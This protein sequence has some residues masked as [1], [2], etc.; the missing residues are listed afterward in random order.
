MTSSNSIPVLPL[1]DIVVFPNMVVPLFVGRE[2]SI[3][4][5][6][7][8]MKTNKKILL[9]TQ[10]NPNI[11]LPKVEDLH[12]IGTIANVLQLLKLPDGTLKVLVEGQSKIKID[13][14]INLEN[15]LTAKYTQ[16]KNS[17]KSNEECKAYSKLILNLFESIININ[18]KIPSEI[19]TNLKSIKDNDSLTYNIIPHLNIDLDKKQ[20]LLEE[21]LTDK[22]M[23]KIY[24]IL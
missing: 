19:F 3:N 23:E 21:T 4:A 15:Y 17:V 12:K 9:I 22:R 16:I 13:N 5:L 10:T 20:E 24:L 1:R 6:N 14:F 18:K 2:A 7:E 11:D 8:V